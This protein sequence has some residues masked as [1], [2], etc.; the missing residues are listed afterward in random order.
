MATAKPPLRQVVDSLYA[1][2]ASPDRWSEALALLADHVGGTGGMLVFNAPEE[3]RAAIVTGRLRPDL[4]DLY[5]RDARYI[6]NPWTT[7]LAGAPAGRPAIA[8]RYVDPAMLRRTVV[9]ADLLLPQKIED[10]VVLTHPAMARGRASGG[11]GITLSRRGAERAEE[12]AHRLGRLAPHFYRCLDISLRMAPH[13]EGRA[14]LDAVLLAMSGPALLLDAAGRLLLANPP[15]EAVLRA[16]DGLA[17]GADGGLRLVASL[18]AETRRLSSR[19]AEALAVSSDAGAALS[20]PFLLSRP[21]GRPPLLVTIIPLPPA[22]FP[23]WQMGRNP[24]ALVLVTDPDAAREVD[25]DA[26]SA[27][28]GI[29]RAEARVAAL[30]A[31]GAGVPQVAAALGVSPTTVKTQLSSC[32]DKT[33]LR[34]QMALARLVNGFPGRSPASSPAGSQGASRGGSNPGSPE[35]S[36]GGPAGGGGN[37]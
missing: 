23:I 34:S 18:P 7:R 5:M 22:A 35:G 4:T 2:A 16:A 3:G 36:G 32:F 11:V 8:S 30:I 10:L 6:D 28:L 26:L 33:G 27:A 24:R 13:A 12:A 31:A 19:I 21:S 1:A 25:G 29:T 20:G 15:A 37:R 14:Q 9:H 17:A